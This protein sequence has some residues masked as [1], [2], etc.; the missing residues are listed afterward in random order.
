MYEAIPFASVAE[1]HV[2]VIWLLRVV[3]PSAGDE[4]T[5]VDG[6]IASSIIVS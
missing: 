4:R 3:F 5:G 1:F 6:G 2:K